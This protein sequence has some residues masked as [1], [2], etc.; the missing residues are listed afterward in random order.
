MM[1]IVT[2]F[3]IVKRGK[4]KVTS[5]GTKDLLPPQ[6]ITEITAPWHL[7]KQK[8]D[9]RSTGALFILENTY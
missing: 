7:K 8:S 2:R 6:K 1:F 9:T 5:A 4:S 3:S